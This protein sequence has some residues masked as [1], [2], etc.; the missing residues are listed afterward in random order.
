LGCKVLEVLFL[1]SVDIENVIDMGKVIELVEIV[2]KEK[3]LK[4]VQMPPKSYLY[5][6]KYGGD[7]RTMP[8]YIESLDIASV[9]YCEL[10]SF[11]SIEVWL[12]HGNGDNSSHRAFYRE[13]SFNNGW[14]NNNKV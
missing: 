13:T 5:F 3:G 12:A 10:T 1:S 11:K 14:Y 4:R 6:T 7:L 9:K 8:A 2:F